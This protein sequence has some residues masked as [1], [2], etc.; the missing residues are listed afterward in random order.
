MR[1]LA[2]LGVSAEAKNKRP[3]AEFTPQT[4]AMREISSPAAVTMDS[5]G[6]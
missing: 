6:L 3:Q 5:E 4:R 2:E 1:I